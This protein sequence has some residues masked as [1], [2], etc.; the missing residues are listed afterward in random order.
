MQPPNPTILVV[1]DDQAILQTVAEIL[2]DEGYHVLTASH[3]AEALEVLTH[4]SPQLIL[5]D[6]RMPE[7]DGWQFA[8]SLT[9]IQ[10]TIPLIVM[11]A[12]QNAH[13]WAREVQAAG[14]VAK[15]FD[16]P[17]LLDTIARQLGR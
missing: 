12:A 8:K 13:Q 2:T 15:P 3:G 4:T 7:M 1:D 17:E 5:L 10:Q 14:Y 6:M 16:L 9:S 11:T